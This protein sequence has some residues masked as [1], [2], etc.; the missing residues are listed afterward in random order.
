VPLTNATWWSLT[1]GMVA[2]DKEQGGVYELCDAFDVPVSLNFFHD[3]CGSLRIGDASSPPIIMTVF[4]EE[5][6]H[7]V[8]GAD[9]I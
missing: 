5:V 6:L 4:R 1:D 2:S 3:F 8:L 9:T 7:A